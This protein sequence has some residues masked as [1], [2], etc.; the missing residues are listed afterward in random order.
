ML[1]LKAFSNSSNKQPRLQL[2][3]ESG[4]GFIHA[5]HTQSVGGQFNTRCSP[6]PLTHTLCYTKKKKKGKSPVNHSWVKNSHFAKQLH[7]QSHLCVLVPE[8]LA[9]QQCSCCWDSP[10]PLWLPSISRFRSM[11]SLL[12]IIVVFNHD[13]CLATIPTQCVVIVVE[14]YTLLSYYDE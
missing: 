5:T 3:S 6:L 9:G 12:L 7:S 8:H 10:Q 1:N 11:K 13:M 2:V 4:V 14:S